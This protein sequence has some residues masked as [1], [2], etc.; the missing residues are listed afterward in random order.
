MEADCD[1]KTELPAE[2]EAYADNAPAEA[3]PS[4]KAVQ[5][6]PRQLL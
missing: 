4:G 5:T 2:S 3:S 1:I 6:L